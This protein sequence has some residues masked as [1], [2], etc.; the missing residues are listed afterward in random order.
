MNI[1]RNL[2]LEYNDLDVYR[3][4]YGSQYNR[5]LFMQRYSIQCVLIQQKRILGC[6]FRALTY[7]DI[8]LSEVLKHPRASSN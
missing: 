6:A 2:S 1:S 3:K 4:P 7:T 5:M 8:L